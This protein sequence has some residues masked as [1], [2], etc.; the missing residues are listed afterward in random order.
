MFSCCLLQAIAVCIWLEHF[1][2]VRIFR[3]SGVVCIYDTFCGILSASCPFK[4]ENHFLSLDWFGLSFV[5][6]AYQT[7]VGHL[8]PELLLSFVHVLG[9]KVW[10]LVMFYHIWWRLLRGVMVYCHRKWDMATR[11]QNLDETD[12]ISHSTNTLGK[13]M[14][15]IILPPAMV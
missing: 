12:C 4:Y 13:G 3:S 15:P 2:F 1:V 9:F 6:M 7:S 5:S 8:M 14:N 11:V 10:V